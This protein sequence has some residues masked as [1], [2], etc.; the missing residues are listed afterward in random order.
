MRVRHLDYPGDV[1]AIIR[2]L[3][4]LYEMNFPG[5]VADTDFLARKKAQIREASR[6]PGQTILVAEDEWGLAG[7][8]W[9]SVEIE[10]NGRRKGEITAICVAN[11]CRG[12]GYGRE[13]MQE[14]EALLRTY[15]CSSVVLMVTQ[16]N[17]SAVHL[18]ESLGYQTTRLQMEK[19]LREKGSR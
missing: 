15:G 16:A 14:G 9:L 10:Y 2:L 19:P 17:A 1:N 8:I 3:P 11:R 5:F 13:L 4:E 7:F 12:K 18:Y 6:D